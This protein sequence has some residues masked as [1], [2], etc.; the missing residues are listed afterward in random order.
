M[1]LYLTFLIIVNAKNMD[2]HHLSNALLLVCAAG[3]EENQGLD[4]DDPNRHLI[5]KDYVVGSLTSSI[6]SGESDD[7]ADLFESDP[8]KQVV[9]AVTLPTAK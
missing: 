5:L 3:T 9:S 1:R 8:E 6:Y 4:P 7:D 2:F